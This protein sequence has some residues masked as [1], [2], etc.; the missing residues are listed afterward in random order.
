MYHSLITS[1][2]TLSCLQCPPPYDTT[3][4]PRRCDLPVQNWTRRRQ[5]NRNRLLSRQ[6]AYGS[7][8]QDVNNSI[9]N[10]IY[11]F[12]SSL[13]HLRPPSLPL[14]TYFRT[15]FRADFPTLL[16]RRRATSALHRSMRSGSDS[17]IRETRNLKWSRFVL[18][19]S[20]SS[21]RSER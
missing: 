14:S 21:R 19:H 13:P 15:R 10:K 2:V 1:S 4:R 17:T 12:P 5:R 8:V 18:D 16:R 3:P 20:T 9:G 7:G 11:S 6:V